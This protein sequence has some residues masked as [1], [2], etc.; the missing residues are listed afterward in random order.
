M[1]VQEKS[2]QNDKE[3]I[4]ITGRIIFVVDHQNDK[5]PIQSNF[6]FEK[7][8]DDLEEEIWKKIYC[9]E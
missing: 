9:I 3:Q 4:I 8:N 1:R 2:T 7:S 6:E 5:V